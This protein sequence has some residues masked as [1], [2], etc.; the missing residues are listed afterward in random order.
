MSPAVDAELLDQLASA[1]MLFGLMAVV[2]IL[3]PIPEEVFM[4][5]AGVLVATGRMSWAE[6][7]AACTFG[8]FT[9]NAIAFVLSRRFGR[10]L[11]SHPRV[12][13]FVGPDRLATWYGRIERRASLA[14]FLIAWG[15]GGRV[16]LIIVAGAMDVP[17]GTF[18]LY[19]GLGTALGVPLWMLL[20]FTF[21]DPLITAFQEAF[22]VM[23]AA[24]TA[25][26]VAAVLGWLAW[27]RWGPQGRAVD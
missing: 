27:K 20:G 17:Y 8:L 9:R 14:S 22:P 5:S 19:N 4:M 18:F 25:L 16:K 21:G 26:V 2:G 6:A 12:V 23:V 1:P 3:V 15:T 13:R 11:L 24:S 7:L 10:W